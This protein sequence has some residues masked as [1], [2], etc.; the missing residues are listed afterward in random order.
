M[1]LYVNLAELIGARIEQGLYRPGD[2]LPSVRALSVEHGVSLSTVQQAYRV[3]EDHGLA[4]PRPKSGYFVPDHRPLPALPDVSRPAQRPV[5][6][7][8][9]DQVFELVRS[10]P[11]KDVVQLG[12]GMPDVGSPTLKPLL[13]S[14]AQLSR[15]QDM[16]GLYYDTVAGTEALR[17]QVARLMLD[18]G[19][20][21]STADLV[22]TTGCQ[23]ALSISVRAVCQPGDIVA[24]ESP[25]FHGAMQTLKGLGMKALEIPTDPLT[26]ISLEALE[27][28]LEQWPIKLIQ[29]TPSCNNP[30]GYIMPEARKRALLTLAQ[31]FDVAILEDDVYGDLAYTY[32]RPRT[33]KSFDDDGR[34]LLCSSFS[35]T[36]A[37]GLRVGWVAPGRYLERVMHMKYISTGYTA[38]QP[39]LAIAD[40]IEGGHYQP[41]LRRVRGQ[42]QRARDQMIDWVS[43]YFPAGTRASRPQGGFVLWVELPESFDTLRLNRALLEQGVQIAV[44]SIFSASGKFRNCLRMNFAARA[45]AEIEAAVRKVG[46]T[47]IR[48]LAEDER[49]G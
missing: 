23:E 43:R 16:P 1:T 3:L 31:R 25:S 39:Q 47:A 4:A 14:L 41:H 46:E 45:T 10:V 2:R 26:G 48:L 42:Y 7:S 30:L 38:T 24:V 6:I 36:L 34:V 17:E 9:W 21:L 28:A 12:R 20:S 33:I 32:P 29:L 13:R 19:C 40:F 15:R 35:K 18:S 11:R 22:I 27:L 37:P 5:D 8:Q 44:G 49:G